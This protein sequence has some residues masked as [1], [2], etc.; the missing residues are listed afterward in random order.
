MTRN[1]V[2]GALVWCA[3]LLAALT[4]ILFL[5][6]IDLLFL[7]APLVVVPL[8]LHLTDQS[9]SGGASSLPERLART[10]HVAAALLA[11]ASFFFPPGIIAAGL[12]L[13][14][15]A[16]CALL[17][18]GAFLRL[19]H[20]AWATLDALCPVAAFLYSLIGAAWLM[21]SRLGLNP[22]GFQ[23]PIVLLTAVHFHYAGFAAALLARS[24]NRAL[25]ARAGNAAATLLLRI[26]VAGVLIGPFLLAAGF[27]VGPRLKLVAALVLAL[28]EI[29]LASSFVFALNR[30]GGFVAQLFL[31][32]AAASVAFSMALAAA[33]AVSEYPLQQFINLDQMERFHGTANAFGFTLCGLLGWILAGV[34]ETRDEG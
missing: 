34:P 12:A 19:L 8:G 31:T 23:E 24:A 16:F 17:A 2:T 26:V 3:L 21:A 7:F 9:E 6:W 5:T 13:A 14:W 32:I 11:A 29:C 22:M 10:I 25:P 15:L 27:V 18:L 33:W 4:N 28:S 20:G 30:V 1:A